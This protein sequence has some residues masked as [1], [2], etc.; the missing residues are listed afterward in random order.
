[1][2]ISRSVAV[3]RSSRAIARP[4][5]YARVRPSVNTRRA[6]TTPGSSSGRNA[7]KRLEPGVVEE[8]VPDVELGL[9]VRL[10]RSRPNRG[11]VT[12]DAEEE[13]DRLGKDRLSGACFS[14]EDVQARPQLELDLTN[15][16]EVLD[17]EAS[18]HPSDGRGDWRP[19]H[20]SRPGRP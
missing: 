18:Q 2:A 4:H 12:L 19:A 9:D 16:D 17:P 10:P 15:E 1:M 13:P 14:T 20:V 3:A 6:R 8:P 5:A 11:G 7:A